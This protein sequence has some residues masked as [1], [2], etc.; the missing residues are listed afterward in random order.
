[1]H[2]AEHGV[3]IAATQATLLKQIEELT[4]RLIE[5][6]KRLKQLEGHESN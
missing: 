5:M 2:V 6:E 3:D 4:L 1:L